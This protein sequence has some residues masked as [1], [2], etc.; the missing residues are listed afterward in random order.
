[1][2]VLYSFNDA[3]AILAG[4][5]I[6]SLLDNSEKTEDI[7]IY[8]IDSGITEKNRKK[9]ENIVNNYGKSVDFFSM[10][11]FGQQEIDT[12]RWNINVFSKLFISRQLPTDVTKIISID[13]DTVIRHSLKELWNTNLDNFVVAGVNEC[14]SKYYRRNLGK[15]DNDYYLNSG[16]LVFNLSLIREENYEDKFLQCMQ[17][18]GSS[19]AYLDQDVINAVVP[20]NKIC[21]LALKY[22]CITPVC[23]LE[24]KDFVETR[25]ASVYYSEEEYSQAK[26]DPYIVH[27]T[28]FFLNELRP[29]FENSSHPRLDDF[30]K[31]VKKSPWMEEAIKQDNRNVLTKFKSRLIHILPK[32]LIVKVGS[33]AHGVIVPKKNDKRMKEALTSV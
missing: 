6:L 17:T 14:M 1:M 11:N 24:Y 32:W 8:I 23:C 29:W 20:Q 9:I 7:H 27:Y 18:Y 33:F 12:R 31:Y 5:S 26:N 25:R 30:I 3:Y 19:L 4:I 10:P 16:L 22:N 15:K 13:C 21:L 28:T 2:N